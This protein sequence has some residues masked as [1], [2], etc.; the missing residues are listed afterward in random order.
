[1]TI[2]KELVPTIVKIILVGIV[3]TAVTAFT[4]WLVTR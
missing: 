4:Y 3:L 2:E 1:M